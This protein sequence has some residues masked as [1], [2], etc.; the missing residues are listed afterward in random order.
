MPRAAGQ[1]DL[2]KNE[3]ILEAATTVLAERGLSA[4]M[5]AIARRAGVSKQTIYNHYGAKTDLLR[6]LVARRVA[7]VTAPLRSPEAHSDPLE[8][9]A[10]FARILINVVREPRGYFLMRLTIQSAAEMPDLARE[11]YEAGPRAA[12]RQLAAF[13]EAETKAGRL[14]VPDP[15][16]GAEVFA[17]MTIGH[18][19]IRILMGLPVDLDEAAVERVA[20]EIAGRFVRAYAP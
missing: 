12:H 16:A 6:A 10:V 8:T 4:P 18:K 11:V 5:S 7:A 19:Q 3:A 15:I 9:L 13:L 2:A 17:G 1:I 14:A 20:R